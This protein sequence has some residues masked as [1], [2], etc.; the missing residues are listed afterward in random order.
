MTKEKDQHKEEEIKQEA[1]VKETEANEVKETEEKSSSLETPEDKKETKKKL[2]RKKKTV[3]EELEE[4]KEKYAELNDKYLRL[5][6]EFDNFRK[7]NIKER[8]ELTK[9]ASQEVVVSMLPIIDDF[10][11]A[12]KAFEESKET[13]SLKEGVTLIYNK[14]KTTLGAKGLECMDSQGKEFDTDY[15]EALTQI[16]APSEDMKGKVVDVIEK[17]YTL[18]GKVIRFAKVVVGK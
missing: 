17:G 6:S 9:T 14:L 16:P 18:G 12:L 5:F 11:R 15:H 7:R 10:E 8:L 13:E 3:A 1:E 2:R 4:E